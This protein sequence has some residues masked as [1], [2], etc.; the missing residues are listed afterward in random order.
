ME[1]RGDSRMKYFRYLLPALLLLVLSVPCSASDTEVAT[2]T[3]QFKDIFDRTLDTS[4]LNDWVVVVGFGNIDNRQVLLEWMKDLRLAIPERNNMLFIA[5]A[6]VR[7][8]KNIKLFAK[9]II[10]DGYRDEVDD[11][12]RKAME[13]NLN[14]PLNINDYLIVV[15]DWTG[16]YFKLFGIENDSDRPHLYIIDGDRKLRG[17]FTQSD[18]FEDILKTTQDIYADADAKKKAESVLSL[19]F[20][21]GDKSRWTRWIPIVLSAFLIMR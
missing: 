5:V 6:D 11:L 4:Q 8:Y 7:K 15:A 3:L 18:K 2:T 13:R 1:N 14:V 20:L 16:E 9:G 10:R 21:G 17:E 12:R 19:K